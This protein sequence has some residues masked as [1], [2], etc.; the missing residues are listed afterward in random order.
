MYNL[1][2][3]TG[4]ISESVAYL[5]FRQKKASLKHSTK[6]RETFHGDRL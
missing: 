2:H 4:D 5:V 6:P 3:E 1:R